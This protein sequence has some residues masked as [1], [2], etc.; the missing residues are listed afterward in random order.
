MA[1]STLVIPATTENVRVARL[2]AVAAA[3]RA[4]MDPDDIDDVRLAVGEAV[5]RAV[6]RSE[7]SAGAV[8][9][10]RL[11]EEAGRFAV[12]VHDA[13]APGDHEEGFAMAVINGLAP[14]VLV[15]SVPEG[16]ET[17]RISWS[18]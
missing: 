7:Q 14:E 13:S 17:Q 11:I 5:A 18:V 2:V 16:G 8:V 3:R 4:G 15:E 9:R 1:A 12:E 6:V 10:I